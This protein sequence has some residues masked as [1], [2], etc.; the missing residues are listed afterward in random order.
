MKDNSSNEGCAALAINISAIL[1]GVPLRGWAI[2]VLWGWFVVPVFGLPA[3]TVMSAIGVS[4]VIVALNPNY[5]KPNTKD[6]T[7]LERAAFTLFMAILFPLMSV[8]IG[9]IHAL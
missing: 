8:G 4:M 6:D 7:A 1:I 9:I 5:S 2:K 3:L